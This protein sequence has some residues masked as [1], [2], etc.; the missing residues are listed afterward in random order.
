MPNR[1]VP[2]NN[3]PSQD[4]T[5][6]KFNRLTAS[7]FVKWHTYPGGT[8]SEKWEFRC[9][10]GTIT[11]ADK[12][13]VTRNH[14]TS[15]GCFQKQ[16]RAESHTKHGDGKRNHLHPL[17]VIWNSMRQRCSD[18]NVRSFHR[19]GG[20]GIKV[21]WSSYEEFKNDMG[22]DYKPGLSI[23]RIDNDGHYCKGN[24]RWATRSEQAYN[25]SH[26]RFLEMD[27]VR[28]P[29]GKWAKIY[30]LPRSTIFNRIASGMSTRDAL[31]TDP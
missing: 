22:H 9:D 4:L 27:G 24:C 23:D 18:P 1:N 17:Y 7:R 15:C 19:Y 26:T 3:P 10:C 12:G 6:I 14:T 21:L 31:T 25:T 2:E 28:L 30:R 13:N 8:S 5:G 20:R 29:L 16:R 11:V